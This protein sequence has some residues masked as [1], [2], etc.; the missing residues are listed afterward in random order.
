MIP[1][2]VAHCGFGG[3]LAIL[4]LP[5]AFRMVPMNRIYGIR[6]PMA[7]VSDSNWYAI[8]AYGGR[9]LMAYGSALFA[10]G[11]FAR[12]SAPPPTS[13]WAAFFIV[14]PLI[15]VFPL[16]GLINAHARRLP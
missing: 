13:I 7:L 1:P 10:F 15:L 6:T 4:S 14:G 11:L 2:V 12:D 9:V 8:N 3:L 5:L 16:L